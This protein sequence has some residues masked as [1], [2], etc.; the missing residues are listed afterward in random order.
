VTDNE[1]KVV[2]VTGAAG[3]VGRATAELLL[4]QGAQVALIDNNEALLAA[5]AESL[6]SYAPHLL[7]LAGDVTDEA[8]LDQFVEGA[9]SRFGSIDAVCNIAGILGPGTLEQATRHSFD[10][11]MHVNCL[12]QLLLVQRALPALRESRRAAV[13]NVASVGAAAALPQMSIY[14]ASKAAVLGLTRAMALELAPGIRCNAVCPGGI[15][16]P[17]SQNLLA[18]LTEEARQALLPRLTGRQLLKRFATPGE[19]A[20][21]IAF[22]VSDAASFIT[23]SVFSADG[24]H[25]AW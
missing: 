22:L 5:T 21:L 16:T 24:G 14:C 13:V 23:G 19:I 9:I 25:G 11:L 15:D 4:A 20:G 17:M 1:A 12:S 8:V 18:S 10:R 3:G 6:R 2:L 7:I